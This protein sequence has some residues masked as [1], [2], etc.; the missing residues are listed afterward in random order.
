HEI[1]E[2]RHNHAAAGGG[3]AHG[4]WL[5][6]ANIDAHGEFGREADKPGILIVVGRAGLASYRAIERACSSAGTALHYA[7]HHRGDLVGRH[8]VEHLLAIVN[9]ARLALTMPVGSG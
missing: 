2:D 4:T 7:F 6:E 8:R 3:R 5:V 1:G 9:D